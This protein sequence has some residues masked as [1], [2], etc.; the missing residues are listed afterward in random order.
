VLFSESAHIEETAGKFVFLGEERKGVGWG[1]AWWG[2]ESV[3][4]NSPVNISGERKYLRD[5]RSLKVLLQK[6][7]TCFSLI[8]SSSLGC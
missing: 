3:C 4:C 5:D 7:N 1:R 8:G 6:L 2:C